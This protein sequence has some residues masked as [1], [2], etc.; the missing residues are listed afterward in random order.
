MTEGGF[1]QS[2]ANFLTLE[3]GI[4]ATAFV[5]TC[6]LAINCA[7]LGNFLVIRRMAMTSDTLS[8][9]VLPGIMGGF[10]WNQTKD[11]VALLVGAVISGLLGTWLLHAITS[12]TK[13]RWDAAQGIVLSLFL[14]LGVC[15]F[16]RIERLPVTNKAGLDK[17]LFGQMVGLEGR[18]LVTLAVALACSLLLIFT[19][20]PS[21]LVLSFDRNYG[22]ARGLPMRVLHAL[23]MFLTTL[24][25][26]VS[27]E[28]VGVVLIS[29]LMVIPVSAAMLWTQR[30]SRQIW[31]AAGFGVTAAFVG[32]AVSRIFNTAAGPS[33]VLAASFIFLV[34]FL[35]APQ[36]S[37]LAQWWQ[38]LRWS[39]TVAAENV[40][41]ALYR[42]LEDQNLPSDARVA[43][44]Q[45]TLRS[46]ISPK[47][48]KSHLRELLRRQFVESDPTGTVVSLTEAGVVRSKQLV[49]AHRLWELYLTQRA[50]YK[51]DHVHDDAE[52][53]EHMLSEE[54]LERLAQTLGNPTVDP[55]GRPIP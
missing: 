19:C 1:W 33:V 40:L 27:M 4:V 52:D 43:I 32:S 11:P 17:F 8:H 36:N 6:L 20:Y 44:S 3:E 13:L 15:L 47:F 12:T 21:L 25:V 34:S 30:L 46:A 53:I 54:D 9:A 41:K 31:L 50:D 39:K 35:F 42:E 45:F 28:A 23:L 2:L 18:D 51:A 16:K 7:L 38:R 49:R 5:G 22:L 10:L 55:H 37:F 14:G 26:V 29:A 48:V 24:A